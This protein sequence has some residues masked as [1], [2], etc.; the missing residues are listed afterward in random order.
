MLLGATGAK[1][2]GAPV[3]KGTLRVTCWGVIAMAATYAIGSL[4][5]TSAA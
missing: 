1:V 5:G 3:A 2:G 4:F